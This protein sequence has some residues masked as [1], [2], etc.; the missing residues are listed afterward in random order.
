M[1]REFLIGVKTEKFFITVTSYANVL[2]IVF[3][4]VHKFR[5]I[6]FIC[7]ILEQSFMLH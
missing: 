3:L 5:E 6:V 1:T 4:I 2:V 7:E